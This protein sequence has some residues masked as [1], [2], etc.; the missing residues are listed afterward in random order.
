[1]LRTVVAPGGALTRT[2]RDAYGRV[3][4]RDDPDR[5]TLQ[6]KRDGFGELISE[7]DAL[8]RVATYTYDALGRTETRIDQQG[9][10]TLTT[11]WTW[12]TA[13][14]GIGK[15]HTL[16]SP[17]GKKT[18]SYTERG[19]LESLML[20][21]AG[22]SDTLQAM[23]GYD[24]LGRVATI[25]Y[26]TPAGAPPF[27]VA[28][29]YDAYGHVL[30]VR[31]DA[32]TLAYWHLTQVDD[33]GRFRKEVFGNGAITE[34]SYFADKQLLESIVT[35][36]GA[37]TVQDLA[38]DY[39]AR[40]SLKS[41]TDALQAQNP[42]ERF[43]YDALDRLTCAY[44]SP[45]ENISL[46]CSLS[47]GYA[48][49]GN[50]TS[51][52]D[53]GTLAYADPLHPHA[54]TGAGSDSFGYDAVGNQ[55]T[56]PGASISYTPFDLPK[57]IAQQGTGTITFAYD[58][59][60]QRIRKSTPSE[61][62]FSFGDLYERVTEKASGTTAHRYYVH[63]PERAVAIVT[64][65]GAKPGTLY[66]HVEHLGS[67]DV[68]TDEG[69]AVVERRSYDPF[70][71]RR[72][73][74]W[75]QPPPMS[76]TSATTQGFTGHESD[77]ELGLVNM[78]GRIYDPRVGRFLMTDPIVPAPF[79]GQG[80]NPYSYVFSNPLAYI[81]PSGFEPEYRETPSDPSYWNN[82]EV[83]RILAEG[84]VGLE[85][86]RPLPTTVE[87][88]PEA[89]Q[90]GATAPP[91][92]VS[93]MGNTAT[94]APQ[95]VT[96]A[97]EDWSKNSYV[98]I[99]GGFLAGLALGFVPFGGVGQQALDAAHMLPHGSA[100]ARLGLAV[101]QL[102]GGIALT[103]GGISGEVLG[104]VAT[105]TGIGAAIGVPAVVVSAALV[106]GGVGNIA[107]GIRGL[108]T[109]GSGGSAA[110]GGTYKLKDADTGQ[111]KRTGRTNDLNR[112]RG[113][114]RRSNETKD[115]EFEVDRRTDNYAQQRGREQVIHDQH[116]EA[117]LNKKSPISPN[118][119]RRNEYLDAAKE[120]E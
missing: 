70:G 107:A 109:T 45:T 50:L 108:M 58:G 10:Q 74:V 72:N 118:N 86:T 19:Q 112:R 116:P 51:K 28:Q 104:G 31:D 5:G 13:A 119:P 77:D 68:L 89:Q 46:P 32:T 26:P 100:N 56:R 8:G 115:L 59:D 90:V 53:V 62:T 98:Q 80:W 117:D 11:T 17:D 106:T 81:D 113:E 21:I 67:V 9:S 39:D 75:G 42:T 4:Q 41:R 48:A 44:F 87:G 2:I 29:E 61:E 33:A 93:P 63:S 88:S 114:H 18:Y 36:R 73:P 25:A 97:P 38:Y 30:A 76:F 110:R 16:A 101:G 105:V 95:P 20:A 52:S 71:K 37:T 66:V 55:I 111:V 47:Y 120:L 78:K 14:H 43:R 92:D 64:R 49:N 103:V 69:G 12:D 99:E 1:M 83:Q 60:E 91:V 102:V 35:Q 96:E 79:S 82:P 7:S 54:V 27:V 23:L 34:R 24:A 15:L 84:C 85:C 94:Y 3:R 22:E 6:L 57:T 65:G 40:L